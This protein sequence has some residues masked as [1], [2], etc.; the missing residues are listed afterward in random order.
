MEHQAESGNGQVE[1][2]EFESV[3]ARDKRELRKCIPDCWFGSECILWTGFNVTVCRKWKMNPPR[4]VVFEG[5]TT[6]PK[7]PLTTS[8]DLSSKNTPK[9][10]SP[11]H[12]STMKF[13]DKLNKRA[14]GIEWSSSR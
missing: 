5:V 13:L 10:V 1:S 14:S 8:H 3:V 4:R 2:S 12:G 11:N 6:L 7:P 9:P